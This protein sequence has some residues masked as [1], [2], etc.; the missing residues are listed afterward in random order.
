LPGTRE[1]IVTRAASGLVELRVGAVSVRLSDVPSV[2]QELRQA[3]PSKPD[4]TDPAA[5]DG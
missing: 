5:R 1:E 2:M 3:V 4:V